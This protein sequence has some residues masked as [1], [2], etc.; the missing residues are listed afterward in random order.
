[1]TGQGHFDEAERGRID[2]TEDS[3]A[4]YYPFYKK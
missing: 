1:M 4:I 3:F 2:V